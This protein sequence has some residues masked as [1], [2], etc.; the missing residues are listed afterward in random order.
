MPP[1]SVL[2]R[3]CEPVEHLLTDRAGPAHG[4]ALC[5][6]GGFGATRFHVGI[7]W[8]LYREWLAKL[9]RI[10]RVSGGSPDLTCVTT[11][12]GRWAT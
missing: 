12:S 3:A 5:L 6:C 11:G 7:V 4:V 9:N 1:T 8:R 2:P 10:S